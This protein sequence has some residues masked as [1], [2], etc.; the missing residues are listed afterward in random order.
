MSKLNK[1]VRD[2]E[3]EILSTTFQTEVKKAQFLTQMKT[4]LG[5]A[6]KKNP[7]GVKLIKKSW[8]ERVKLFFLKIFTKF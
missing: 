8:R 6:I 4:G 7:N 5:E 3:K 2:Y 1:S